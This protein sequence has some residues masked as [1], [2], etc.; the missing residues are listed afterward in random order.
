MPEPQWT[1][2]AR[3]ELLSAIKGQ[4]TELVAAT[5]EKQTLVPLILFVSND[6]R[7]DQM[8][9]MGA[10][11]R[12]AL[13][14]A[15]FTVPGIGPEPEVAMP[16]GPHPHVLGFEEDL[17]P[18]DGTPCAVCGGTEIHEI[19]S[20]GLRETALILRDMERGDGA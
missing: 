16:E 3:N 14:E 7:R 17:P 13:S 2:G 8:E 12:H 18:V 15:G 11:L 19:V 20:L 6:M 9:A 5:R 1:A 10:Y 4:L